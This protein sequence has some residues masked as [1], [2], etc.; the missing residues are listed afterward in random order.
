M[1][2]YDSTH[3]QAINVSDLASARVSVGRYGAAVEVATQ[4][5]KYRFELPEN[6]CWDLFWEIVNGFESKE[7]IKIETIHE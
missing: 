3:N 1:I 2:I 7:L 4:H 5:H 6:D